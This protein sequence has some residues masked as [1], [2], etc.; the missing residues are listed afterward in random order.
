MLEFALALAVFV[1]AHALPRATGLR[2]R[3]IGRFGRAAY[4]GG[5]SLLSVVLLG[6]LIAAA[7]RAP[8]IPLWHPTAA[9]AAAALAAMLPACLLLAGAALRPNPLSVAFAGGDVDPKAPGVLA[10][11]RHPILWAF[12]LW[13]AGHAVA[14]GDV[15]GVVM[16]GGFAAFSLAGMRVLEVRTRQRMTP[17]AW[18]N[19]AS[20]ATGSLPQRLRR[21]ASART[22]AEML[23]GTAFYAF[24]LWVHPHLFG[25]DPLASLR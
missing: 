10:I 4:L 8:Y 20:V 13:A 9:T 5:Y 18:A 12:F 23:T 6:W 3:L 16:F 19:A 11:T 22:A 7:W 14:N 1:A 24:L 15:V 17:A 2:D 21:A 25:V